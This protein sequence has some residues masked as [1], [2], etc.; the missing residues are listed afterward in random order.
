MAT[1]QATYKKQRYASDS[2]CRERWRATNKRSVANRRRKVLVHYSTGTLECACCGEAEYKF[3]CI[4]HINGGGRKHRQGL[5]NGG[6]ASADHLYRWLL[7][8]QFP[9]GFQILCHN[10]NSAK[11]YYGGC[12][13]AEVRP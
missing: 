8:E 7:K 10:C 5:D 11:G 4:D 9:A 3:L 2:A 1:D 6:R 12:P 13:H